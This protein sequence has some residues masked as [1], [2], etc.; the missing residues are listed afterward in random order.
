MAHIKNDTRYLITNTKQ[1]VPLSSNMTGT[2]ATSGLY[3]VGVGTKFRTQDELQ[4]GGWLVDLTQNTIRKID[5]VLDDTHAVLEKAF[6]IDITAGTTPN[7][8]ANSQLDIKKLSYYIDAGLTDGAVDGVVLNA[9]TV[10][11]FEKTGDVTRD[12][13]GFVDPIVADAAG[14]IITIN[15]LR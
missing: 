14:T 8:I 2:I 10:E 5:S 13:F 6:P 7:V 9:G 12:V 11:T 3:I 1:S 15:I 4:R